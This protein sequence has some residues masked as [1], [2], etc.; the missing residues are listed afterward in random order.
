MEVVSF[1]LLPL[2]LQGSSLRYH[3]IGGWVGL[4]AD[5]DIMEKSITSAGNRSSAVHP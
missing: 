2:Y 5:L 1:L 4:R 3:W